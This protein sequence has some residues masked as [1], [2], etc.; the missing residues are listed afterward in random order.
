VR[1][2]LA[3]ASVVAVAVAVVVAAPRAARAG[4]FE[5]PDNGTQALGRGAAFVAKADDP[6][7]IYWNPAGLARQRGTRL[8]VDANIDFH[9]FSFQ[10]LGVFPDDPQD[11]ATPWGGKPYPKVTN[12][13][14]PFVA[15]FV[16]ATSDFGTFDRFTAAVGVFGPPIV[17]NRTF[18]L[19]VPLPSGQQAPSASRY[20][21]VQSRSRIL[22]PTASAAYRVL[23]WLDLGVSAHLVLASF[24]ETNISFTEAVAGQCKNHEYQLCDSS[25]TLTA[26]TT[27][28]AGTFGAV[29]RPSECIAFGAMVRTPIGLTASGTYA[30]E[31]PRI[32]QIQLHDGAATFYT[33]LPLMIRV[34]ARYITMDGDFELYDLEVDLSYEAW[35]SAQGDGPRVV[36]P[37]LGQFKN[38]NATIV[39]HYKD[40]LGIRA[41]GA[42]NVEGLGGVLSLR[43][44]GYFDSPA[45]EFAYT[46][47]DDDTL[48]KIAGTLG[49]GYKVGAFAFDLAYAAVASIPR[50]VGTGIGAIAPID[51]AQNGNPVDG[52]GKPLPAVNEGAYRGFTHILSL[53]GYVTFDAFFGPAR[54]VHYGNRYEPKYVPSGVVSAPAKKEPESVP[55]A[56]PTPETKPEAERKPEKKPE[57]KNPEPEKKPETKKPE[58]PPPSPPPPEKK[59]EW[60]EED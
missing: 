46:R 52:A 8:L 47:V 50:V 30:P 59:K 24:D 40:T 45:T 5:L 37:D 38:I 44:G 12:T 11:P 26:S 7:A 23:P 28:F 55:R 21:F 41:G 15:P 10:R 14:G 57:E 35:G 49:L 1:R 60:W 51:T 18:P 34:G 33:D 22:Y 42:Y 32:A 19:G 16:A 43:A 2:R 6:T 9:S 27:S 13:A 3:A 36:I 20:D 48:A 39:H 29:V 56:A 53:G 31:A 54:Q 4:G 58:R 17:A 25:G